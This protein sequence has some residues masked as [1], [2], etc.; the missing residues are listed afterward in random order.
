MKIG[1]AVFPGSNCDYDTYY[2]VKDILQEDAKLLYYT[3]TD[4]SDFDVVILPGGFSF[5][6]YL[7][8]GALASKTPLAKAIVDFANKGKYVL[9]ICNGFQILTEL[10]LLPGAL[11]PN[12]NDKFICKRQYL[13]VGNVSTAFTNKIVKNDIIKLP[14]AHHDGRFYAPEDVLNEIESNDQVILRYV[15]ECGNISQ[16]ANPN[17]SVNNIAGICNKSGNVAG[18]MPHPERIS[19]DIL[20]GL[21]GLKIWHSLIG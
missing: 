8:P 2:V 10:R 18:M 16:E 14:I 6:D 19:E 11:L 20:D 1:I 3:E 17:G 12:E 4:L 5:G 7:R 15:D 9:G 21:D 13:V